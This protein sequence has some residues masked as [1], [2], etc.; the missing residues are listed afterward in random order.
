MTNNPD[1]AAC[2]RFLEFVERYADDLPAFTR[3]VCGLNLE[4]DQ[5]EAYEAAQRP[6]G[7]VV[8][9]T[10]IAGLYGNELK[11]SVL[12]P[13]ALWHFFTRF[14]STT[15][16]VLP[17]GRS[18]CRRQYRDLLN[19]VQEGPFGWLCSGMRVNNER[20]YRSF[21]WQLSFRSVSAP[22]ALCGY[23]AEHLMWLVEA[24]DQLGETFFQVMKTSCRGR[25]AIV[26]LADQFESNGTAPLHAGGGWAVHLIER[27]AVMQTPA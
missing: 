5:C 18:A 14:K 9:S 22:E 17:R 27:A 23:W 24:A 4:P 6:E 1:L 12:A 15:V 10:Y 7:R 26:L 2:P 21:E 16:V 20:F 25:N 8:I 11:T 13:V 3:D 19:R